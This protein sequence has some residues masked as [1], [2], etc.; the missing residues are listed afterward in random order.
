MTLLASHFI[1]TPIRIVPH[2][3]YSFNIFDKPAQ[4]MLYNVP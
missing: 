2:E 3:F 4:W 1:D